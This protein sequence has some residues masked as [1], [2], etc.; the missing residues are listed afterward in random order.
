MTKLVLLPI[1]KPEAGFWFGSSGSA[2]LDCIG[3]MG[4]TDAEYCTEDTT[5]SLQCNE[6][7]LTLKQQHLKFRC[8]RI[9]SCIGFL[10]STTLS[11]LKPESTVCW[12]LLAMLSMPQR[13]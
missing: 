3:L 5:A 9:L 1:L 10:T 2:I 13:M 8:G 4:A 11:S 12:N 7:S 6:R